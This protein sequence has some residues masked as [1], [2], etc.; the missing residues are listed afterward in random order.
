MTALSAGENHA[1]ALLSDGTVRA[2]GRD[3]YGQVTLPEN[4]TDVI[5]LASGWNFSVALKSDGTVVGW[6]RNNV[7]QLDIPQDLTN[8]VAIS[9]K[10][11]GHVMALK[12]DGEIVFWGRNDYGESNSPSIPE[13]GTLEIPCDANGAYP[14]I[15]ESLYDC[16]GQCAGT[17]VY[18][19]CN[20]CAG[21]DSDY[22][23][24]CDDDLNCSLECTGEEN[25]LGSVSY[26]HLTLPTKA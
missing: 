17:D 9:A 23:C 3:N 1:V 12:S 4:L 2:W 6:G 15:A 26:T 24:E 11:D 8:V 19:E 5:A 13:I 22:I 10:T 7:G 18:D 21:A 16:S 14:G 20:Y 25:C